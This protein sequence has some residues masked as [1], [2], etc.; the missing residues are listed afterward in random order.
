MTCTHAAH[1]C[2]SYLLNK[3]LSSLHVHIPAV[4]QGATEEQSLLDSGSSS[5]RVKLLHVAR[6]SRKAGLLL[7]VAVDADVSLNLTSCSHHSCSRTG[8]VLMQNEG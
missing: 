3:V 6:H 7:G 1:R 2:R 8:S 5:V 4:A